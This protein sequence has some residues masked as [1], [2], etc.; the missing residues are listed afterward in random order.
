MPR[1]SSFSVFSLVMTLSLSLGCSDRFQDA[2]TDRPKEPLKTSVKRLADP[3]NSRQLDGPERLGS[4]QA[5]VGGCRK[6]CEEGPKA[7]LSYMRALSRGEK[8]LHSI[9]FLETSEMVFNGQRRGDEWIDLW[10]AGENKTR[11]ASIVSF[12]GEAHSWLSRVA[13]DAL[14]VSLANHVTYSEDDGPGIL[15]FWKPPK[16]ALSE[17]DQTEWRY[18]IQKRGWEWLVSEI[19]TKEEP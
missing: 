2:P 16:E 9:P 10:K 18:R 15:V 8:G 14:E 5:V 3:E 19:Q 7:F 17:G 12:A 4:R 1:S 13:P 11:R 6:E